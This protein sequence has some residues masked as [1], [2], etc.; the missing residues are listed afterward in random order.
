[1]MGMINMTF[2]LT[3]GTGKTFIVQ[4]PTLAEAEDK[5]LGE[6]LNYGDGSSQVIDVKEIKQPDRR[7]YGY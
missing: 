4:E 6:S 5:W 3:V 2:R 7:I 1:M